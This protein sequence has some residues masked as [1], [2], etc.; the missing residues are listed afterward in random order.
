MS[1]KLILIVV[2]T[3]IIIV[4][5]L[6]L[7]F[8]LFRSKIPNVLNDGEFASSGLNPSSDSVITDNPVTGLRFVE[9]EEIDSIIEHILEADAVKNLSELEV[10]I[11]EDTQ[12]ATV[13]ADNKRLQ[14]YN[15]EDN[16]FYS[17]TFLGTDPREIKSPVQ[18][19]V[20]LIWSPNKE[21]YL[22]LAEDGNYYY[23]SLE[24]N[25][26][27]NL[28]NQLHSPVFVQGGSKIAY[29][30]RDQETDQYNICILDP[31][32]GLE[33]YQKLLPIR[34]EVD[35]RNIPGRDWL[36]YFLSPST[37]RSAV[38]YAYDFNNG[39]IHMLVGKASAL[40][41]VWND[42]G[43]VMAYNKLGKN[44][45]I[46]LWIASWEG[47]NARAITPATFVDKIAWSHDSSV[48]YVAS[49]REMPTVS[50]YYDG[51]ITLDKF[52]LV[53]TQTGNSTEV[54]DF[55]DFTNPVTPIDAR[56]FFFSPEGKLLY[57]RNNY[58]N[59]IFAINLE[60]I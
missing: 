36:G 42:N 34:G 53:D 18:R 39:N 22:Y 30:F 14:F 45:R 46:S 21:N 47:K 57:F 1:K 38:I 35:L 56:D 55:L 54:L 19:I 10:V 37:Q 59:S 48:L 11:Y 40:D 15:N 50:K 60:L 26:V 16:T 6:L 8:F 17:V 7:Y 27:K 31:V 5:A 51:V 12:G 13:S 32:L 23:E 28:G 41:G 44:N 3:V 2:I 20:N 25:D 43:S 49:P 58:D 24:N 9:N 4:G 33:S 52:Y 29:Q